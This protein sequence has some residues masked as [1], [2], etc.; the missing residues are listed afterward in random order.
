[1]GALVL[2]QILTIQI[3]IVSYLKFFFHL[4]SMFCELLFA[5]T[6]HTFEKLKHV[7]SSQKLFGI[8]V[9]TKVLHCPYTS[10]HQA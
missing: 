10:I 4:E 6:F 1:M 8:R 5:G 3:L 2:G 9:T 7:H